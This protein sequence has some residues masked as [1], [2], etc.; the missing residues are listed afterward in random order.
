MQL[1]MLVTI[2]STQTTFFPQNFAHIRSQDWAVVGI[3]L[4]E[5]TNKIGNKEH[6]CLGGI[7]EGGPAEFGLR[8]TGRL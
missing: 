6:T 2:A 7:A 4:N 8:M 3:I 5:R 1:L